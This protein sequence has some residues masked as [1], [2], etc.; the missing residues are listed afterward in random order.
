MKKM[1]RL[2]YATAKM[3]G[4]FSLLVRLMVFTSEQAEQLLRQMSEFEE[5]VARMNAEAA[6]QIIV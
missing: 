4:R 5:F 2:K 6:K 3:Q 1:S